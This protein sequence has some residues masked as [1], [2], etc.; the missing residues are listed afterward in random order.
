MTENISQAIGY[1]G[2]KTF[3]GDP[4]SPFTITIF[5]SFEYQIGPFLLVVMVTQKIYQI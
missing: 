1:C 2:N 3:D 4:A 5:K